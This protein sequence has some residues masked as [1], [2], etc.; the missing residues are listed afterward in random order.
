MPKSGADTIEFDGVDLSY[1]IED[2]EF[3]ENFEDCTIK[4]VYDY[5]AACRGARERGTG[6]Q[7]EPDEPES[8]EINAVSYFDSISGEWI[9]VD[10]GQLRDEFVDDY[11]AKIVEYIHDSDYDPRDDEYE[12]D[13][14]YDDDDS[15]YLSSD[16][17]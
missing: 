8:V 16:D 14:G 3:D 11:S 6:L 17:Y 10:V 7:L 2:R 13:D 4:I 12:V 15:D 5:S 9:D 1:M